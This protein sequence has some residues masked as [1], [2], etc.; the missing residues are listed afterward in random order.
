MCKDD[1]FYSMIV[2]LWFL[3]HLILKENGI[4]Q[5]QEI[6]KQFKYKKVLDT[7]HTFEGDVSSISDS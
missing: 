7:F 4:M 1:V 6:Y 5:E 3:P 2:D